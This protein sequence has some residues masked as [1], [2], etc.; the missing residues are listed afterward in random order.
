MAV[1]QL[2]YGESLRDIVACLAAQASKLHHMGIGQPVAC[3]TLAD[4]NER[5]DWRIDAEFGQRL[6]LER[7][8]RTLPTAPARRLRNKKPGSS[9]ASL[10]HRA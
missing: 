9:R 10:S 5:R 7:A 2:C 1:A 4:A 6:M 3:S 8:R